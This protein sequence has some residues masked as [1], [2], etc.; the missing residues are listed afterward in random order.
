MT[1]G[2]PLPPLYAIVD[3]EQTRD[4]APLEDQRTDVRARMRVFRHA[5]EAKRAVAL[6]QRRESVEIVARGDRVEN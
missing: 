3:P 5:D 6:E 4:R 1:L 2:I